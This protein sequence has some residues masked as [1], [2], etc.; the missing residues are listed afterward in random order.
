MRTSAT[1]RRIRVLV[2]AIRD[3]T[4]T[5]RPEFQRRLVWSNRHKAHFLDTVLKG[6]PFPEIYIAAG[7]VD[8]DTGEGTEMLVDG[9]QRVTTLY[10]YFTGS[11][12]LRLPEDIPAYQDL[13]DAEKREFLEYEVVIRDLG[14]RSIA[15]IKEIFER[16]NSTK[17]ALNAMEVHNARY[18]GAF[19]QFGEEW[20]THDFFE[21]H[22][23]FHT[24]EVRRMQDVRFILVCTITM[25]STYF[26]RDV[27][28]EEYLARF[29]E[30]FPDHERVGSELERVLE[31]VDQLGLE[32][33]RRVWNKAD[34]LTLLVEIHRAQIRERL[35]LDP[36]DVAAR[37][38]EFYREADQAQEGTA[39]R[40]DAMDYQKATIQASNDRKSRLTRGRIIF[41]VI[42]GGQAWE[43]QP[44]H[45]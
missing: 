15:D 10:Q 27:E 26:H 23:V 43:E 28:L 18:G 2:T 14:S 33:V 41:S 44:L 24:N 35:V 3:E 6:Y 17:Y 38:I 11:P 9:Q 16:I 5:P 31:Y 39:V 19:K 25:M 42:S 7:D 45:L 40:Q 1:N 12:D 8:P 34:L 4:L 29:N 21:K 20:A 13:A 30:E 32:E 36:G 37:L 22:R